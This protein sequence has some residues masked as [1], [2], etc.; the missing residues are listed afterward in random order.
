MHSPRLTVWLIALAAGLCA[1]VGPAGP[2]GAEAEEIHLPIVGRQFITVGADVRAG[3][4]LDWEGDN[5]DTSPTVGPRARIG[6]QHI[7][8][9]RLSMN[10]EF[11][12]GATYL[13][14]HP[15]APGGDADARLAFD[16]SLAILGRY[17]AIGPTSGWTF[18]GGIHYRRVGLETGSLLQMGVDGR[19]GYN[20][21]TDDERFVLIE[22]GIHA[23]LLE[24]VNL[25]QRSLQDVEDGVDD[26]GD[27]P[28][29]WYLPSASLGIQ[30]AF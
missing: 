6:L 14:A 11:A 5:L 25:P 17:M 23:P 2:V 29:Q 12:P 28:D 24:G 20:V 3:P 8:S 10:L 15:M 22:L 21:W 18:A 19:I 16:F 9:Q 26:P 1:Y 30:W 4:V 13:S 7:V 27:V